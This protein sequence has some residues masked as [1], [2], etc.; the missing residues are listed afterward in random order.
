MSIESI[1]L[2]TGAITRVF[3]APPG[4]WIDSMS[5]APDGRELVMA[6]F[7]AP[8][9]PGTPSQQNL[10][11]FPLDGSH[12]P[13]ALMPTAHGGGNQYHQPSWSQDG[14]YIYYS[15]VDFN[16]PT[17]VA[18]QHFSFYEI[19]RMAYPG[20]TPEKLAD[21]AYWPRLSGDGTRLAYVTLDPVDGT[22]KLFTANPDGTAASQVRSVRDICP[23][24]H[25]R[26]P[27]QQGR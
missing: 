25:R 15:H 23:I 4:A 9:A 6:Y 13:Q 22:N 1:D 10:F 17:V 8:T 14:K 7:P 18:G 11:I 27:D 21:A 20:G 5:V 16:A 12:P 26:A 2:T 24:D 3:D 19:Y